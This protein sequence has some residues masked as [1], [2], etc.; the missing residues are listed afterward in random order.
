MQPASS[1]RHTPGSCARLDIP[2]SS[3]PLSG[4]TRALYLVS[5]RFVTCGPTR[6]G[7]AF[8]HGHV[9]QLRFIHI[10]QLFRIQ[11]TCLELD[12][13]N[14]DW[15]SGYVSISVSDMLCHGVL[16]GRAQAA[17]EGAAAPNPLQSSR[18]WVMLL[19]TITIAITITITG[20]GLY[21]TVASYYYYR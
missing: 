12:T 5:R 19:I 14:I 6:L 16:R 13:V 20:C 3:L 11:Y 17:R 4:V 21:F 1:Q 15:W 9:A 8:L 18:P 10:H 7:G 2:E